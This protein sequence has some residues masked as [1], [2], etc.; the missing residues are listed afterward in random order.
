MD[1]RFTEEQQNFR[2]DVRAFLAENLG[3]DWQGVVPDDYFTDENWAL[4]RGLTG[5]LVDKGWLTLAWPKEYGGQGRPHI[6]QM[7]YN[8]ETAYFRAPMRDT[9][10]GTHMVG[11]S[12]MMYG[13]DEQKDKYLSEIADGSAVYCQGFSEPESGSDLASLQL[14]A[15]ED[16]DDFVLN[17]SKVWTSGAH[18]A[19]RCYIMAR[20][21]PDAPK[22]RGISM[23]IVDM[24]TPG[25]DVRPIIN[26]HNVHYFNQV[27]FEDVRVPKQNMIGEMNR[28]W[29]VAATTLDFERSGVGRYAGN[30]RDLEELISLSREIKL[31]GKSMNDD[32]KFRRSLANLWTS[33][34]AGKLVAYQVAWMQSQGLVPNKEAS[35]AKLVGSEINQKI[36]DLGMKML[37]MYGTLDKGSKW[38]YLQGRLAAQWMNSYSLTLRAGTSE[39]QRNIIAFRGLGLPRG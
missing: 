36:S 3:D 12:I 2:G 25:I 38:A 39:I 23:F 8:E 1:F 27:F 17:G 29:Y 18:K 33:N 22:H 6:E 21:E 16:G 30:R 24:D 7:I 37:G 26:M 35:V 15:V 10:M 28:G 34:E 20:T 19:N 13:T 9:S 31:N 4:I 5:K 32:P 14:Q 11:P